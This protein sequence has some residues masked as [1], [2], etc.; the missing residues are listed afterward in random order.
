[1]W[2]I[3]SLPAID[4]CLSAGGHFRRLAGVSGGSLLVA[5]LAVGVS[6]AEM[7]A[8]LPRVH[9]VG[10]LD[11]FQIPQRLRE[12]FPR[13]LLV[14][15]SAGRL[16]KKRDIRLAEIPAE[17]SIV[18]ARIDVSGSILDVMRRVGSRLQGLTFRSILMATSEITSFLRGLHIKEVMEKVVAN[19]EPVV[20][21]AEKS[22]DVS[23][24]D[25]VTA[26][27][28]FFMSYR[29]NNQELHDGFYFSNLP[30]RAVLKAGRTRARVLAHQTSPFIGDSWT[31]W[32]LCRV[33]NSQAIDILNSRFGVDEELAEA[34]G[35]LLS[36]RVQ[37][38]TS[39]FSATLSPALISA[40]RAALAA[41]RYQ[42]DHVLL[43]RNK[44]AS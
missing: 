12:I 6:P 43:K 29:V 25:A 32:F 7:M 11:A 26:S 28:A 14:D 15:N 3:S 36:P 39:P 4:Y 19:A 21:S 13:Q 16:P 31:N 1:M 44:K 40:G 24:I 17:L 9:N 8:M 5:L 22:P 38:I 33:F 34:H 20:L 37:E 35:V 42:I 30:T 23:L 41:Q 18:C 2:K 10:F 27:C